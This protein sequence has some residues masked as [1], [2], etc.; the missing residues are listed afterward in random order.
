MLGEIGYPHDLLPTHS[1]SRS[2]TVWR[3]SSIAGKAVLLLLTLVGVL[4]VLTSC[5]PRI[6]RV[7]LYNTETCPSPRQT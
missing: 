5:S 2:A 7:I 3:A 1:P 6:E 4:L